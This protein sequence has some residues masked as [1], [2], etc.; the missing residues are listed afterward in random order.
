MT[1]GNLKQRRPPYEDVVEVI[2]KWNLGT[3][4]PFAGMPCGSDVD[5][6]VRLKRAYRDTCAE[7]DAV[8]QA[9]TAAASLC[10]L[11]AKR[12]GRRIC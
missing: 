9:P 10:I 6:E 11:S 1:W 8:I 4:R 7:T 3:S 2:K 12:D 5:F